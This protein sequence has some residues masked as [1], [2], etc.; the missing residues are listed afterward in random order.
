MTNRLLT[1]PEV[2]AKL[3]VS[4]SWVYK[5]TKQLRIPHVKLGSHIR[6]REESLSRW[7][8]EQVHPPRS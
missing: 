6:F 3:R 5:Q 8:D 7:L 4:E 1:V 2:A